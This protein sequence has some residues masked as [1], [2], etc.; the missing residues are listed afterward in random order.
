MNN[1]LYLDE[2]S[3]RAFLGNP[4]SK[5]LVFEEKVKED[6]YWFKLNRLVLEK[7]YDVEI[8][9][10]GSK[11]EWAD[12][13][14]LEELTS[15]KRIYI[16]S[17]DVKDLSFVKRMKKLE[18]LRVNSYSLDNVEPLKEFFSL[19]SLYL[20]HTEKEFSLKPLAGL[21]EL[22]DFG[23]SGNKSGFE[24][25]S[26]L[27]IK[28]L[29]IEDVDYKILFLLR[30][31]K[32]CE[33]LTLCNLDKVHLSFLEQFKNLKSLELNTIEHLFQLKALNQLEGLERLNFSYLKTLES[34]P[35][36]KKCQNL[37]NISLVGLDNLSDI[38]NI[39]TLY[40][41]DT[42]SIEVTKFLLTEKQ[43]CRLKELPNL[44]KVSIEVLDDVD[45]TQALNELLRK[46]LD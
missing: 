35:L 17:N 13:S 2:Q 21:N 19:K 7:K 14:F 20:G 8:V 4:N 34:F 23:V 32:L 6:N 43:L 5:R 45:Q 18:K 38:E 15:L 41:L 33:K 37:K 10:Y 16:N 24:Y 36:I 26:C 11:G 46:N 9:L 3:I 39:L 12:L 25:L 40:N 28:R 22:N 42:L 30:S 1:L 27:P 29:F 44:E 31:M